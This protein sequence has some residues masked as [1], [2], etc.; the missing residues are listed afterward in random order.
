MSFPDM[1]WSNYKKFKDEKVVGMFD[2]KQPVYLIRDPEI[3]KYL[4]VKEFDSFTDH[5][6]VIDEDIDPLFGKSL[7]S[8]KGDKWKNMRATLSPAFTGSKMR[9]MFHLITEVGKHSITMIKEQSNENGMQFEMKDFLA[10]FT[11]DVIASCAFGLKVDSFT[12]PDNDFQRIA[13]KATNFSDFLTTMKLVLYLTVP[14][15]TKALKLRIFDKEI[16]KFFQTTVIDVM[17][18]REE[19]GIVRHDMIQLL[20]EAKKGKLTHIQDDDEADGFATVEESDLGKS[21]V[22][23]NWTEDDLA[24]Q[25]FIFFFA[26]FD[27]VSTTMA[28]TAYELVANPDVQEKLIEEVD[29]T[30]KKLEGKDLT[31]EELQKMKY[32]DQVVSEVLRI[33]P[34]AP[35]T[36]RLC[37]KDFTFEY[38]G[39]SVLIEKGISLMIPIIGFHKDEKYFPNPNKFDP[40]RFSD[41][42][43][44]NINL[45]TYL[46]FGIGP[47]NCIGSR[48]ALLEVKTIFYYL[49]LNFTINACEKTQIPLKL[50]K[51]PFGIKT[52][53]GIW[54]QFKPR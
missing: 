51:Q 38:D 39:K 41:E 49:L 26:G 20:M 34:A 1:M 17:R 4:A 19:K 29:A 31:Y 3:V 33:W 25:A 52:E 48:F 45:N 13:K 23:R 44:H 24:A 10:K 42:N 50:A 43:K 14:K 36:D 27:T 28:F 32:L 9:T 47:R 12:Y 6:S 21:K 35:A 40:D 46:P 18:N 54:V 15:I 5:R 2:F 37:V 16:A 7:V 11:N 30:F 53:K 22:T 8:L